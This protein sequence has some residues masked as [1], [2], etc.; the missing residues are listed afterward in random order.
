L[1]FLISDYYEGLCVRYG[2][3]RNRVIWEVCERL[4]CRYCNSF[5]VSLIVRREIGNIYGM[6]W[7]LYGFLGCME[8]WMMKMVDF[9]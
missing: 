5:I 8:D 1:I 4:F 3:I 2:G 7:I 6:Y 9:A